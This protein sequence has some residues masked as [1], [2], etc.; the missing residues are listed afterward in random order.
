[1]PVFGVLGA[2]E[3]SADLAEHVRYEVSLVYFKALDAV[4][5]VVDGF[6]VGVGVGEIDEGLGVGAGGAL[7]V[8]GGIGLT[9]CIIFEPFPVGVV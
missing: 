8:D 2:V 4:F 1:M 9:F 7:A 5:D 3:S 6:V